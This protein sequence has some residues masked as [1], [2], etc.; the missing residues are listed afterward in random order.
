MDNH[1]KDYNKLLE[2]INEIEVW[3]KIIKYMDNITLNKFLNTF[4][5]MRL[6]GDFNFIN[7]PES[8][9]TFTFNK[10]LVVDFFDCDDQGRT[11]MYFSAD[12]YKKFNIYEMRD[13]RDKTLLSWIDRGHLILTNNGLCLYNRNIDYSP[14]FIKKIMVDIE[15]YKSINAIDLVKLIRKYKNISLGMLNW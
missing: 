1:F 13:W 10:T 4:P 11:K 6:F 14:R 8:I 2:V 12:D 3:K 7:K 9:G 15:P 5:V